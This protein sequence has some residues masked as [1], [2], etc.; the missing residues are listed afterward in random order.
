MVTVFLVVVAAVAFTRVYSVSMDSLDGVSLALA[1]SHAGRAAAQLSVQVNA[2]TAALEQLQYVVASDAHPTLR[3]ALPSDFDAAASLRVGGAGGAT[4]HDQWF[5]MLTQ[6]LQPALGTVGAVALR[7]ADASIVTAARRPFD[8][9]TY[10]YAARATS[11]A[12]GDA[13]SDERA[14]T[15]LASGTAVDTTTVLGANPFPIDPARLFADRVNSNTWNISADIA[16]T[17]SYALNQLNA[18][19]TTEGRPATFSAGTH[20]W[21]IGAGSSGASV[22]AAAAVPR[23]AVGASVVRSDDTEGAA[24]VSLPLTLPLFNASGAL[25]AA[26]TSAFPLSDLVQSILHDV[27]RRQAGMH[28]FLIDGSGHLLAASIGTF[29]EV[30]PVPT[31][32]SLVPSHCNVAS[33]SEMFCRADAATYAAQPAL[34]AAGRDLLLSPTESATVVKVSGGSSSSRYFVATAPVASAFADFTAH[35]VMTIPERE[36]TGRVVDETAATAGIVAAIIVLAIIITVVVLRC[37]LGPLRALERRMQ[38]ATALEDDD[39]PNALSVTKEIAS[40]EAAY[41]QMNLE[42]QRLKGFVSQS[43]LVRNPHRR[44]I[45][46]IKEHIRAVSA[47]ANADS[48]PFWYKCL[49]CLRDPWAEAD[50]EYSI[51]HGHSHDSHD[52]N[53]STGTLHEEMD[54]GNN[55]A[56][57]KRGEFFAYTPATSHNSNSGISGIISL[58][59]RSNSRRARDA[60][61]KFG[62]SAAGTAGHHQPGAGAGAGMPQGASHATSVRLASVVAINMVGFHGVALRDSAARLVSMSEA[63]TSLVVHAVAEE[64][65]VVDSFHGDHFLLTFN[66]A[67]SCAT[68]IIRASVCALRIGQR[69]AGAF[70]E[71]GLRIAG[72]VATS[73]VR[74]G[75]LGCKD[76]RRFSIVG[77]AVPKSFVL[78]GL[79]RRH[80]REAMWRQPAA[81][82]Y[83]IAVGPSLLEDLRAHV[84]YECVDIAVLPAVGAVGATRAAVPFQHV[85]QQQHSNAVG[86]NPGFPSS[87][88]FVGARAQ[89]YQPPAPAL[90]MKAVI[91]QLL[92]EVATTATSD[93]EEWMYAIG[94]GAAGA[95]TMGNHARVQR[96]LGANDLAAIRDARAILLR[97]G[98]AAVAPLAGASEMTAVEEVRGSRSV[99]RSPSPHAASGAVAGSPAHHDFLDL[100]EHFMSSSR[101][102]AASAASGGVNE[103]GR[104]PLAESNRIFML[105]A[106]V[107]RLRDRGIVP[108]VVPQSLS[109]TS[110]PAAA[111]NAGSLV[112][113]ASMGVMDPAAESSESLLI[114]TAPVGGAV[115]ATPVAGAPVLIS[116]RV[117]VL[118][119]TPAVAA[120]N[121]KVMTIDAAL[122]S[123]EAQ[124][125][126]MTGAAQVQILRALLAQAL[127]M[128]GA[129]TSKMIH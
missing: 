122:R 73:P 60:S 111:N 110:P 76:S 27:T 108:T 45:I 67:S 77:A 11:G 112:I 95:S 8:F 31:S 36:L 30:L 9:P 81:G 125:V 113:G 12:T 91:T 119:P 13:R 82:P 34:G 79:V 18:L 87:M 126:A 59:D 97:G 58:G 101:R 20:L 43:I 70:G 1:S 25:L 62:V 93:E 56:A 102:S 85:Q 75:N 6:V 57:N 54:D 78:E 86:F 44:R 39:Q 22:P 5:E 55:D 21:Q 32:T 28:V 105:I 94:D 84:I 107:A 99:L 19:N 35:M 68:H 7:F 26:V 2:T 40:I 88:S 10:L 90:T 49:G 103:G 123:W 24:S 74:L 66:V 117:G 114:E 80:P 14:R 4:W 48:V 52:D 124:Y 121:E 127:G 53:D 128:V 98:G 63:L 3:W 64:R 17:L 61:A 71:L 50:E 104:I 15:I 115:V 69:A 83:R 42:L 72:G 116:P 109:A 89:Q 23:G 16:S 37:L 29:Y 33:S 51:T 106:D 47:N 46:F 65:G 38:M 100:D 120:V 41:Y 92:G 96:R 129:A 118:P